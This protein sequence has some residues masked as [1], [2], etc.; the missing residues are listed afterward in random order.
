MAKCKPHPSIPAH[1]VR[2]LPTPTKRR[3]TL[4]SRLWRKGKPLSVTEPDAS[5]GKAQGGKDQGLCFCG[6]SPDEHERAFMHYYLFG[7]TPDTIFVEGGTSLDDIEVN[8]YYLLLDYL[9]KSDFVYEGHR[10]YFEQELLRARVVRDGIRKLPR[11]LF[12]AIE[13]QWA[14]EYASC[15]PRSQSWLRI[16]Q[17][18]IKILNGTHIHKF[19][20]TMGGSLRCYNCG[21]TLSSDHDLGKPFVRGANVIPSRE[22]EHSYC[23]RCGSPTMPFL[24]SWA[25]GRLR[26]W[27]RKVVQGL[28]WSWTRVTRPVPLSFLMLALGWLAGRWP[29]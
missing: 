10:R 2:W 21:S 28:K 6:A 3:S 5:T 29:F 11:N 27:Y 18:L 20:R 7:D 24:V 12:D 13:R 4:P 17:I 25:R 23:V 16:P 26:R 15:A 9:S 8:H 19:V 14:H 22:F 1:Y